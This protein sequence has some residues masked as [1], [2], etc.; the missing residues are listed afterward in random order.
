MRPFPS[1][2]PF[3]LYPYLLVTV[4]TGGRRVE[5]ALQHRTSAVTTDLGFN[6]Y[7]TGDSGDGDDHCL[8]TPLRPTNPAAQHIRRSLWRLTP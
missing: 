2:Q 3:L 1:P 5:K 4:V 6:G 8:K 7:G